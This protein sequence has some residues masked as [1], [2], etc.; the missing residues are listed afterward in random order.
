MEWIC[1]ICGVKNR[2]YLVFLLDLQTN[3]NW[4][5]RIDLLNLWH[6]KRGQQTFL[7]CFSEKPCLNSPRRGIFVFWRKFSST[8]ALISEILLVLLKVITIVVNLQKKKKLIGPGKS[9]WDLPLSQA[10]VLLTP[11]PLTLA[12]ALLLSTHNQKRECVHIHLFPEWIR[13]C[14]EEGV[15]RSRHRW[16][17]EGGN[18]ARLCLVIQGHMD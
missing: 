1:G 4:N 14:P 13:G 10:H 8:I 17:L 5:G 6:C 11:L 16:W 15:P 12:S 2:I 18:F 3:A 7:S 9:F